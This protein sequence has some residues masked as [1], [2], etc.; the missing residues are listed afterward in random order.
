MFSSN[1]YLVLGWTIPEAFGII[2]VVGTTTGVGV[3]VGVAVP[4]SISSLVCISVS[5]ACRPLIQLITSFVAPEVGIV[6]P[7]VVIV[8]APNQ[9]LIVDAIFTSNIFI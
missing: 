1:D 7:L 5:V 2:Q 6:S 8:V 3:T 4:T 9:V